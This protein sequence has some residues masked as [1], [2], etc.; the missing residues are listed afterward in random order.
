MIIRTGDTATYTRVGEA[1][2]R[3]SKRDLIKGGSHPTDDQLHEAKVLP[4]L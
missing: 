2:G 1:G 4:Y 3:D